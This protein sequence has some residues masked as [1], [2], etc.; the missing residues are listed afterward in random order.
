MKMTGDIMVRA[1]SAVSNS[2]HHKM[3]G[4]ND[5]LK[6]LSDFVN[7]KENLITNVVDTN[8]YTTTKNLYTNSNQSKWLTYDIKAMQCNRD[9]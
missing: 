2:V 6:K 4:E 9:C 7:K 8:R 3:I 5:Y 1:L